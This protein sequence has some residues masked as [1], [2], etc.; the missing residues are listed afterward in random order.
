MISTYDRADYGRLISTMSKQT[1]PRPPLSPSPLRPPSPDSLPTTPT[2]RRTASLT[3]ERTSALKSPTSPPLV[4]KSK[5]RDLLRKHYGLAVGP[6]PP[7]TKT[8]NV[9]DPMD[10]G[11]CPPAA[12]SSAVKLTWVL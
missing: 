11:M 1:I 5:A 6:P 2:P 7:L 3:P 8:E 4:N 12:Y 9:N 10:L